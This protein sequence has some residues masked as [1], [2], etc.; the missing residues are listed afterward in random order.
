[1]KHLVL[2]LGVCLSFPAFAQKS[3]SV[4]N[5]EVA[6]L[7][8]EEEI[9]Q[10][11][12]QIHKTDQS[13]RGKVSEKQTLSDRENLKRMVRML[14]H[15]GYPTGFCH[16]CNPNAENQQNFT[17]NIVITHNKVTEVSEYL[18]PILK[19]ANK[20]GLANEFWYLHNLRGLV[21][22]RYGRDFYE[23]TAEN[24]PLFEEKIA[25]FVQDTLAYDLDHIDSLF[26]HHDR[27]LQTI[28]EA[29]VLLNKKAEGIRHKVYRTAEGKLFWQRIY[30]DGSFNFPVEI[31]VE[32]ATQ[33]LRYVL[34][35]ETIT[36]EVLND[37]ADVFRS[38]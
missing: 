5:A 14:Y 22:Q 21:R 33:T 37:N 25:P 24:I 16:G 38:L 26:A 17:P 6:G 18:F 34:L 1:M 12:I 7:H 13:V 10:A 11:W 36:H 20:D 15:H 8:S 35:D 31:Y 32:T 28:L 23:K 9:R 3:N 29:E 27:A 4:I 19:Q 30:S 2:C